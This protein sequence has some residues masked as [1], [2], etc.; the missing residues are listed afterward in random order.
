M[1]SRWLIALR[2]IYR[3]G[4]GHEASDSQMHPAICRAPPAVRRAR[5]IW[6]VTRRCVRWSGHV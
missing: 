3:E 2:E 5:W 6:K 1:I 4:E